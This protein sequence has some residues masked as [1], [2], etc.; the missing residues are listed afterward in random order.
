MMGRGPPQKAPHSPPSNNYL[1]DEE[2]SQRENEA[3]N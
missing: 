3:A 2:D 1:M